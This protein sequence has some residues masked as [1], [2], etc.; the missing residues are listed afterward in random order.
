MADLLVIENFPASNIAEQSYL[1]ADAAAGQAVIAVENI[2]GYA[3]DDYVLVGVKGSETGQ[4]LKILSIAS[5]QITFLTNL[6]SPHY[7]NEPIYKIKANQ[8]KIYRASNV[9][10]SIPADGSFASVT[11][12]TRQGDQVNSSYNDSTG[13]SGYWY[14]STDYNSTSLVESPLADAVAVRGGNYGYYTT[15]DDVREEAGFS[16]NQYITDQIVYDKLIK[17]QSEVNASLV[18]GGYALP[19][20]AVPEIVANATMLLAAGYLLTKEYGPEHSGTNKEGTLKIAQA[21]DL[22]KKIESGGAGLVDPITQ[23]PVAQS[24]NIDGYPDASAEDLSPSEGSVFKVTDV[25]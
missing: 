14:K 12:L 13:G 8:A 15:A 18:I 2:D 19:L 17:A 22:L 23:T 11:T 16:N 10:G 5:L 4:I 9:D 3:V 24:G 21:R 25:Y 6:T 20:T 1:T 7:R